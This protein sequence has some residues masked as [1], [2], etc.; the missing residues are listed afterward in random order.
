MGTLIVPPPWGI[1]ARVCVRLA[2]RSLL[3]HMLAQ[4]PRGEGM[5]M[6]QSPRRRVRQ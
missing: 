5:A 6:T 1:M 2:S 4:A 3:A